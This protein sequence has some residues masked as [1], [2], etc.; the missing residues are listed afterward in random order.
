MV[1]AWSWVAVGSDVEFLITSLA[2]AQMLQLLEEPRQE[3]Q[4]I[5]ACCGLGLV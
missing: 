4:E 3:Q 5:L 2:C 1:T